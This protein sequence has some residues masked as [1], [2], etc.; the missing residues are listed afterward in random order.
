M[1]V[2]IK[3]I[4]ELWK[5]KKNLRGA[6]LHKLLTPKDENIGNYGYIGNLILRIYW[7]YRRN[8]DGYFGKKILIGKKLIKTHKNVKKKTS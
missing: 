5:K 4:M 6:S 1:E 8:M 2:N 3:A 7:I